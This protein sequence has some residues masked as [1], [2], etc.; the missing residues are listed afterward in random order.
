MAQSLKSK[1]KKLSEAYSITAIIDTAR[2]LQQELADEAIWL[3]MS[4]DQK[5]QWFLTQCKKYNLT[6]KVEEHRITVKE[7]PCTNRA[8]FTVFLPHED[9]FRGTES[10]AWHL[11]IGGSFASMKNG[12]IW[13]TNSGL[14]GKERQIEQVVRLHNQGE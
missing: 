5:T 3:A 8:Y 14:I 10:D 7:L 9:S 13:P 2:E 12:G 1:V 11:E 6:A 4:T